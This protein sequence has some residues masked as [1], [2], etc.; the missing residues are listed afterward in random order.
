MSHLRNAAYQI[1]PV[2]WMRDIMD[3]TLTGNYKLFTRIFLATIWPLARSLL[4]K[5]SVGR[6]VQGRLPIV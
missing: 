3:V 1:D 4:R 5:P 2:L 6:S